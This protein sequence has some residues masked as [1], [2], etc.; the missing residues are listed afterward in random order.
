MIEI[1]GLDQLEAFTE[2]LRVQLVDEGVNHF[3]S[4]AMPPFVP[5]Q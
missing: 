4:Y 5:L 2:C 1:A 3:T